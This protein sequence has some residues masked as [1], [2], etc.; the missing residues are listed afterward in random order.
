MV[1][2]NYLVCFFT[3]FGNMLFLII[4]SI[5]ERERENKGPHI[6]MPHTMT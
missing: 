1:D 4:N 6:S 2:P 3:S 5:G